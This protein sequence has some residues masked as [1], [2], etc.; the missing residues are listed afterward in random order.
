MNQEIETPSSTFWAAVHHNLETILECSLPVRLAQ[1]LR[2]D[3][4]E[5]ATKLTCFDESMRMGDLLC[6]YGHVLGQQLLED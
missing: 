1:G 4:R 5:A 6:D 2:R 3:H